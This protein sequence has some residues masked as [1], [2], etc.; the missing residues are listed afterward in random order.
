M[1]KQNPCSMAFNNVQHHKDCDDEVDVDEKEKGNDI[2]TCYINMH[3]NVY[4]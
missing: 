3:N 4:V 2:V 1:S